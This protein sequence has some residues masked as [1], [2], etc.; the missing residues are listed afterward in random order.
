MRTYL[1]T[2]F[3]LLLALIVL[4]GLVAVFARQLGLS[5]IAVVF[6]IVGLVFAAEAVRY[7]VRQF[8]GT[9]RGEGKVR[10]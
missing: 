1:L 6:V 7:V 2:R 5:E 3:L 4:I 8:L 10:K 9:Y